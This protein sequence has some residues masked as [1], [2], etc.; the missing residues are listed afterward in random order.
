MRDIKVLLKKIDYSVLPGI[1]LTAVIAGIALFLNTLYPPLSPVIVAIIAG[2]LINNVIG[3]PPIY[4][5]GADYCAN[6]LLKMGIIL[7]GIRLSFSE[8]LNL[9][10]MSLAIIMIC[11]GLSLTLVINLS[12][13][14]N[15][16]PKLATLIAIG[17][18]IC[19]NTAIV[20]SAPVIK[21]KEGEVA[22]AV[23]TITVFGLSAIIVY[24]LIGSLLNLSPIEFGTWVGTAINDTSQ[25]VAAGFIYGGSAGEAA[26]VVKLTRNLFITPVVFFFS[27]IT[28]KAEVDATVNNTGPG[29]INYFKIFPWF[30]LGFLLMALVR[31]A[32]ILSELMVDQISFAADFLLVMALG[33]I[34][35]SIGIASMRGLG[36]NAFLTGLLAALIVGVTSLLLVLFI[37]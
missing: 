8:I 20:A 13:K 36:L 9:G 28:A 15:V 37:L 7:L 2:L 6:T 33:G 27:Y 34:G 14:F 18:A 30:V 22:F 19:G 5:Q 11:I 4:K 29:Q 23:A 26:T 16:P 17:T 21:A 3:L 24:P 25:V 10:T 1:A 12:R 32:G 31:T 35:M